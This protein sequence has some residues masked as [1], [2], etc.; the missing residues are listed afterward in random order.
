MKFYRQIVYR[1]GTSLT[2]PGSTGDSVFSNP[3]G[4]GRSSV[5]LFPPGKAGVVGLMGARS[6]PGT[7]EAFYSTP[8]EEMK[9]YKSGLIR[10]KTA[11]RLE[12]TEKLVVPPIP[13]GKTEFIE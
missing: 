10:P 5:A 2:L 3:Q 8:R 4:S 12:K 6:V 9:H 1:P 11:I 7:P 13:K